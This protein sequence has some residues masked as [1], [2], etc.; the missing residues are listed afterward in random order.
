MYRRIYI[1]AYRADMNIDQNYN[2]Y[3][4]IMLLNI[5]AVNN[6]ALAAGYEQGSIRLLISGAGV[7]ALPGNIHILID[8][9]CDLLEI[10]LDIAGMNFIATNKKLLL[11]IVKAIG[12][13]KVNIH[14]TEEK[15]DLFTPE[16]Y[17]GVIQPMLGKYLLRMLELTNGYM[18]KEET[19][20]E[21]EM[22]SDDLWFIRDTMLIL[23]MDLFNTARASNEELLNIISK[24]IHLLMNIEEVSATGKIDSAFW[25]KQPILKK[26]KQYDLNPVIYTLLKEL[27]IE[28]DRHPALFIPGFFR[29][30]CIAKY[31]LIDKIPLL[32]KRDHTEEG[33]NKYS[34]FINDIDPKCK[35][36]VADELAK[37]LTPPTRIICISKSMEL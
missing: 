17:V 29:E 26:L 32:L 31:M 19:G 5:I 23:L 10:N 22:Y 27:T 12:V 13:P 16:E 3:N 35:A 4:K 30:K 33:L 6:I 15:K 11:E 21:M 37:L 20:M 25:I 8:E 18:Y 36:K 34:I 28:Y 2:Y 24:Y 14:G 1:K 7:N 9:D